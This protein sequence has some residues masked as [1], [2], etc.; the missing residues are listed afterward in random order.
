MA[1]RPATRASV[2][3]LPEGSVELL[4]STSSKAPRLATSSP[5]QPMMQG[6]E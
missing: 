3:P 4:S 1:V 5:S 6:R 2:S